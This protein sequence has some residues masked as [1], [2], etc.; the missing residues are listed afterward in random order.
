MSDTIDSRLRRVTVEQLL[1]HTS[2][3]SPDNEALFDVIS[4]SSTEG[5]NL[6]DLRYSVFR[7]W[8]T[9]ALESEPGSRFAYANMNYIIAGAIT[10]RLSHKTWEELVFE[11]IFMPLGLKSASFG[12][13]SSVGKID[14]PVGHLLIDGKPKA[15]LAGPAGVGCFYP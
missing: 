13:L 5:G 15:I 8:S 3:I 11:R 9:H 7:Q 12:P 1:S 6:D 4:R 10:E 14:A 2:G